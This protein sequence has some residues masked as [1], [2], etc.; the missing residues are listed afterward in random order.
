[1]PAGRRDREARSGMTATAPTT[2]TWRGVAAEGI[3]DVV[4][5][6]LSTFL[7]SRSRRLLG[8]LLR[9]HKRMIW[10]S[11]AVIV[12][13]NLASL[14]GPW[15]VHLAIDRG[16]PPLLKG[17]SASD[18]VVIV[19]IF[20]GASLLNAVC[21]YLFDRI[22]GRVGQDILFDLRLRLYDHFQRLS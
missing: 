11:L 7:R 15:L 18:L 17:G 21:D 6:G 3:D 16:I 10:L 8:S 2:D 19:V 22:T 20:I 13:F 5:P 14:A 9:P 1:Q 4:A 12:V